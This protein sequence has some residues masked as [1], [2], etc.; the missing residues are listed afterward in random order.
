MALLILGL[1]MFLGIHSIR[2]FADGLRTQLVG[3]M[4]LLPYKGL[5][6]LLSIVG[7]VFLVIGFRH[8]RAE[9][10]VLYVTPAWM[11]HVT[12]VLMMLSLT[13]F[14]AAYIPR[15]WFK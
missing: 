12:A 2:I 6:T 14:V 5:Y 7:F 11:K 13:L 4:G 9:S 3:R 1:V 8:A 10:M 15:N